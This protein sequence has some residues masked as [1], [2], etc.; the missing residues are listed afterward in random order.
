MGQRPPTRS[1]AIELRPGSFDPSAWPLTKFHPNFILTKPQPNGI[2]PPLSRP[3]GQPAPAGPS[4]PQSAAPAAVLN[5]GKGDAM[6]AQKSLTSVCTD[7]IAVLRNPMASHQDLLAIELQHVIDDFNRPPSP[8]PTEH[9]VAQSSTP[10]ATPPATCDNDPDPASG[11][12]FITPPS[13]LLNDRQ[14]LALD[15][16]IAVFDRH[17]GMAQATIDPSIFAARPGATQRDIAQPGATA[18][19]IGATSVAHP[20]R[21][22][23]LC[24]QQQLNTRQL[25]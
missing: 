19:N 13:S 8:A 16:F 12:S 22:T 7:A 24:S 10:S 2:I 17:P 11:S 5:Q 20:R 14:L 15:Q 3:P 4:P 25:R 21:R 9:N 18:R 6:P 23:Q 1:F